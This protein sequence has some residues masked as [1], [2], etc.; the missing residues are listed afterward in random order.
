M[1]R[2]FFSL[3]MPRLHWQPC[4]GV[5]SS[6]FMALSHWFRAPGP[7]FTLPSPATHCRK[8]RSRGLQL[9]SAEQVSPAC[10]QSRLPPPEGATRGN[11]VGGGKRRHKSNNNNS[12]CHCF[13]RSHHQRTNCV[14]ECRL[15]DFPTQEATGNDDESKHKT[16]VKCLCACV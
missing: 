6:A 9:S 12:G 11:P 4:K 10:R 7:S 13:C 3:F 1:L 16:L 15:E 8:V 2:Q 5:A 14:S